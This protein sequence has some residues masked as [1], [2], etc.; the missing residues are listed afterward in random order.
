MLD[1]IAQGVRGFPAPGRSERVE[2]AAF[3]TGGSALN[4]AVVLARLGVATAFAGRRGDDVAGRILGELLGAEPLCVERVRVVP[5]GATSVC[6]VFVGPSGERNFLVAPGVGDAA[7]LA[8]AGALDGVRVLHIGDA[9]RLLAL[10]AAALARAAKSAGAT[11]TADV[12]N[13]ESLRR[14]D[15]LCAMLPF[16]DWFLPSEEEALALTGARDAGAAAARLRA[17]GARGVVV[18]RGDAGCLVVGAAGSRAVTSPR[19]AVVDTTGAGDSFDAG[20][21]AALVRGL[22]A[23]D[24]ARYACACGACQVTALG[25][26]AG[27]RAAAD[28]ERLLR[29]DFT[30]TCGRRGQE[31]GRQG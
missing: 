14:V 10:D 28:V 15:A 7:E 13:G 9:L 1:C 22:P 2:R 20:F 8:D 31:D 24:A 3:A 23:P 26:T 11:V 27:I 12:V 30:A 21:V 4:T 6:F 25:A 18:K 19:V 16:I 5:G 17:W 29:A